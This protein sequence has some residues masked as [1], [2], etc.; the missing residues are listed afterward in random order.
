MATVSLHGGCLS[1]APPARS[2][3]C[4]GTEQ[5]GSGLPGAAGVVSARRATLRQPA[6]AGSRPAPPGS[7]YPGRVAPYL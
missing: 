5:P 3:L 6:L 1:R 7:P 2:E 4:R